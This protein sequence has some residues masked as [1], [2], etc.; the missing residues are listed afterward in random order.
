MT[1]DRYALAKLVD[2]KV[3]EHIDK[4]DKLNE[5]GNVSAALAELS[6]A[7]A[8]R[9]MGEIIIAATKP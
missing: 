6:I 3:R 2:D 9:E 4:G 1:I 8:L 7:V 5:H